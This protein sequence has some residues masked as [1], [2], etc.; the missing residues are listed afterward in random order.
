MVSIY[1]Q[2][3]SGKWNRVGAFSK[4]FGTGDK[5]LQK[6]ADDLL[7]QL[8]KGMQS[9]SAK[10][11][12]AAKEW[13][14]GKLSVVKEIETEIIELERKMDE[15]GEDIVEN[16]LTKSAFLPQAALERH[17]LV[18][19]LDDVVDAAENAIRVMAMGKEMKP[20][21]EIREIGMKIWICTDLLQD[22]VKYLYTD[23]NAAIEISRKLDKEREE[24]RDI[25]FILL[26]KLFSSPDYPANE[27]VFFKSVS[28]RMVDVAQKAEDASDYIRELAVKYS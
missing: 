18:K 2:I 26:A 10:L 7:I 3:H 9:A 25:Q 19:A 23:F 14:A 20:P 1:L 13:K 17:T 27:V 21:N 24:A 5:D 15:I 12:V 28:E 8:S 11:C 22:A 6:R 16:I 4:I